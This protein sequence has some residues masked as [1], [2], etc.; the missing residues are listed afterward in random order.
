MH[1]CEKFAILLKIYERISQQFG[2]SASHFAFFMLSF[3]VHIYSI[4]R[5]DTRKIASRYQCRRIIH[6]VKN[7]SFHS[8]EI[9]NTDVN[10]PSD[11]PARCIP[12]T[13]RKCTSGTR[14]YAYRIRAISPI[15]IHR[16]HRDTNIGISDMCCGMFKMR[17]ENI[18]PIINNKWILLATYKISTRII[19][20]FPVCNNNSD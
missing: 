14:F 20:L 5:T 2:D 9:K 13:H 10:L 16:M 11:V 8:R 15:A 17:Y 4:N 7:A 19:H 3:L 1:L 18:S 6:A 12:V